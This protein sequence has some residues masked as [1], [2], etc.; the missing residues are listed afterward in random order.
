M[1]PQISAKN[2]LQEINHYKSVTLVKILLS[3]NEVKDYK[4]EAV[5]MLLK[6]P[7]KN[8]FF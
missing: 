6:N 2:D 7:A 1:K 4:L 5:N 8:R 3:L